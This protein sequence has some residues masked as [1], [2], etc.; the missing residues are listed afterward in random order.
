MLMVFFSFFGCWHLL[1]TFHPYLYEPLLFYCSQLVS[2]NAQSRRIRQYGGRVQENRAMFLD[3]IPGKD[4]NTKIKN[5]S[6]PFLHCCKCIV[7][8]L[9]FDTKFIQILISFQ[10]RFVSSKTIKMS[11]NLFFPL[12]NETCCWREENRS[13]LVYFYMI[14]KK[15][16]DRV[17]G[18]SVE[19][20][21][22]VRAQREEEEHFSKVYS[23][24]LVFW[25]C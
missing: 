19:S 20:T 21:S 10:L 3:W 12:L 11:Q 22:E 2:A 15:T 25:W 18:G 23:F 14:N 9:L 16:R 6:V 1:G 4:R 7:S 13:G 5:K 24:K 8:K 17:G